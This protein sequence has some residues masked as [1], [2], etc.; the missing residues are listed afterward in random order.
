MQNTA[1]QQFINARVQIQSTMPLFINFNQDP[2][3][4]LSKYRQQTLSQTTITVFHPRMSSSDR[5]M[6]ISTSEH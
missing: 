2:N 5:T 1:S 6:K 3:K 4:L